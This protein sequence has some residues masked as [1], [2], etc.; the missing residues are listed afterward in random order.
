MSEFT[1]DF[2]FESLPLFGERSPWNQK[3]TNRAHD[4]ER[5]ARAVF[6][7]LREESWRSILP[8]AIDVAVSDSQIY[9]Q[10]GQCRTKCQADPYSE[11][12]RKCKQEIVKAISDAMP[13]AHQGGHIQTPWVNFDA[14]CFPIFETV[15]GGEFLADLPVQSYEGTTWLSQALPPELPF[16]PNPK[17]QSPTLMFKVPRWAIDC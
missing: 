12:C 8:P 7:I 15:S 1:R 17:H 4:S 6:D 2:S 16:T 3:A 10:I 9:G 11:E 5:R 13:V 14:Y